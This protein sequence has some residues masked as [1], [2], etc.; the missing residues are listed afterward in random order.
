MKNVITIIVCALVLLG[1]YVASRYW[2]T[3]AAD[4]KIA[5]FH[6][7]AD[8]LLLALQQ[9]KEFVGSY[10]TGSNLEIARAM[11]GQTEK[12][13]LIL[14]VRKSEMNPKGEI[15]DPW[16]TPLQFYFAPNGILIRSAGP[17]GVF[18]DSKVQTSDDLFRSN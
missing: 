13:V 10:P 7:A 9:Y 17:N 15:V 16:G 2:W 5:K 8:N 18:E 4:P 12:K 3:H 1:A 11:T 14:T 6:E